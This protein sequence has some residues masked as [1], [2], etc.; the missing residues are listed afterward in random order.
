M[1]FKRFFRFTSGERRGIYCLCLIIIVLVCVKAAL[2]WH[3]NEM[4]RLRSRIVSSD[5]IK[6]HIFRDRPG[7]DK[8]T[9]GN[10]AFDS[11]KKTA[12]GGNDHARYAEKEERRQTRYREHTKQD[13]KADTPNKD[14]EEEIRQWQK[15]AVSYSHN[16]EKKRKDK[17]NAGLMINLNKADTTE[18]KKLWGIGSTL[19]RRIIRFRDKLGGFCDTKQLAE[20]YGLKEETLAA[21]LP[22]V[23]TQGA[24]L[25]KIQINSA[26][27]REMKEHPYISYYMAVAID[28]IRK[29]S[30]SGT[31]TDYSAIAAHRDFRNAH[32]LL[33]EYISFE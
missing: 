27:V 2:S 33:K 10:N 19:S 6:K 25:R 8:G 26:S 14:L 17:S 18:L 24:R 1:D 7:Q 5:S 15:A 28:S 13:K 3:N 20:I 31:I 21:M 4:E 29:N 30:A 22:H 9:Y 16:T 23:H 11:S 32:P 12:Q